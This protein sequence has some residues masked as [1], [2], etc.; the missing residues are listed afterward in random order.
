MS[1]ASSRIALWA[2]R[3]AIAAAIYLAVASFWISNARGWDGIS[4]FAA[5]IGFGAFA[6]P[7]WCIAIAIEHATRSE[8]LRLLVAHPLIVTIMFMTAS[9]VILTVIFEDP[10]D[11]MWRDLK[12]FAFLVAVSSLADAIAGGLLKRKLSP[13]PRATP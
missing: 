11:M 4:L 2:I 8:G 3:F 13:A 10:A 1:V 5:A 12:P 9:S 7:V 6:V